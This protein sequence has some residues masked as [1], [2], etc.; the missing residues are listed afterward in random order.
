MKLS[1]ALAGIRVPNWAALYNS[2]PDATAMSKDEYEMVIVGPYDLPLELQ[3]EPNIRVVKDWGCPTRCYQLAILHSQGEYILTGVADDGVCMNNAIDK[4]FDI[5]PKHHKGVVSFKYHEGN[6]T[7]ASLA[8]QNDSYWRFGSHKLHKSLPYVY[9][10]YLLTMIALARRDYLMEVGGFDCRFEQPG[11]ALPDL[12][13]RLQND[14]AEVVL[15][16]KMMDISHLIGN[17][18]DHGPVVQAFHKND[19]A[20]YMRTYSH[21]FCSNRSK[22]D[23]DNWK[24]APEV[25]RRRFPGGKA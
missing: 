13:V 16:E 3:N 24:Q 6:V 7:S 21:K 1:I 14:G 12:A 11:L 23:F 10:H 22:I 18:G 25:W 17:S 5:I 8:T 19:K 20:L 9:D 4:G 2:I 15:G